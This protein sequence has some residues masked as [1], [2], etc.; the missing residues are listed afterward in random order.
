LLVVSSAAAPV[1]GDQ[2]A[3]DVEVG[4]RA[5]ADIGTVAATVVWPASVPATSTM[6]TTID[7]AAGGR[8]VWQPCPTISV[9]GSDHI[10]TTTVRL[11]ADATAT[12]VE[13]IALGRH[14]EQSGALELRLRVE[15]D[16]AALVHH[17]ERFGPDRPGAGSVVSTGSARH[18]VQAVFVG[19][20]TGE[21]RTVVDTDRAAA[22][23]PVARDAAVALA[24]AA[25][26]PTALDLFA[27]ITEC[28]PWLTP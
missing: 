9:R 24:I 8:L 6:T 11:A 4:P 7:V 14:G 16:G 13:E 10:A 20:E 3:L 19:V 2:L 22:W 21:P 28:V 26:R 5:T 15:R 12:I 25:D 17:V 23:L 1:G 27:G 18:V